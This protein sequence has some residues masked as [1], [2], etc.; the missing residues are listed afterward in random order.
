MNDK[1]KAEELTRVLDAVLQG[2]EFADQGLDQEV[3]SLSE[4]G[5]ALYD[6]Q[7]QVSVVHR[8]AVERLLQDRRE[9]ILEAA[10]GTKRAQTNRATEKRPTRRWLV[11]AM[12]GGLVF[13]FLCAAL[14]VVAVGGTAWWLMRDRVQE[15]V[16]ADLPSATVEKTVVEVPATATSAVEPSTPTPTKVADPVPDV[17][18][19]ARLRSQRGLVEMQSD[20]GMWGAVGSDQPLEEGATLRTG[21]LSSA[22]ILFYDG[23]V[24]T[25][26]PDTE[27]SLDR[28]SSDADPVRVI[29]M[30][31]WIGESTHDVIPSSVEG[32]RYAVNTPNGAGEAKGTVFHVLVSPLMVAQFIV[33]EGAVAVTNI[34]VTVLVIAGQSTLIPLDEPPADPVFRISGEGQVT[35]KG[36]MWTIAGQIFE[37]HDETVVFG[38][39]QVGDWVLVDGYLLPEGTRVADRIVLLHRSSV[40]RFTISGEVEEIGAD[41]WTVAGQTIAVTE[42]TQIDQEIVV[43]DIV[44]VDGVIDAENALLAESIRPLAEEPA[45][46]FT[47]VGVIQTM[48]EDAWG[49]SGVTVT[50]DADT[51]MAE[52]LDW[53]DVVVV[54]GIA[55]DEMWLARS[56]QPVM[57]RER[58]FEFAGIVE[59]LDP[60]TVSGI[61]FETK[62]WTEIEEG[63]DVDLYV[64]VEGRV[65]EDGT[66]IADEIKLV[67]RDEDLSF[68]FV[69]TVG[70]VD[71]VEPLWV[72]AGIT[73]T[74]DENTEVEGDIKVGDLVKVEG[75]ITHEGEWLATEIR[76]V[77]KVLGSGCIKLVAV[78]LELEDGAILLPNGVDIPLE[79]SIIVEGDLVA[80]AVI[81][82]WVCVD[83]DGQV[84]VVSIV[85]VAYLNP[86][87][88][89]IVVPPVVPES[90][91]EAKVAICHKPGTKAEKTLK[92][93]PDAVPGH[94]GHGDALGACVP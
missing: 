82:M 68:E 25:L 43:W 44:Q 51:V 14:A 11:P 3:Q 64:K 17:V 84:Y 23:S 57:T 38:S 50:V 32:A 9:E 16:V 76:P 91:G 93:P 94:L 1:R 70:T 75:Q 53:G 31:Q 47:F 40:D 12:A 4:V 24:A 26:G 58:R 19:P 35:K 49:V 71:Q 10:T 42:T 7:F 87:D 65:L 61:S 41:A 45:L 36:D 52:N 85:V 72:V 37:T 83:N 69:G 73:L 66:W 34:E 8:A 60:W 2:E 5:Q 86:D 15:T 48:E 92:V 29:E 80:G 79:D 77:S 55:D 18:A 28:I 67:D 46:A 90:P 56:I 39:P 63:V 62:S 81:E 22:E 78:V 27:V 74:V 88:I 89:I 54:R 30:T 59:D 6:A 33:D 13:V 20:S 21:A